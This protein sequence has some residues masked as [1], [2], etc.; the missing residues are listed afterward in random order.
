M[1]GLEIF[2]GLIVEAGGEDNGFTR[3]IR[4][5][6]TFDLDVADTVITKTTTR[7]HIRRSIRKHIRIIRHLV[8]DV[9]ILGALHHALL[10]LDGGLS[11]HTDLNVAHPHV[12]H[13]VDRPPIRPIRID[14]DLALVPALGEEV[15]LVP[16]DVHLLRVL[17]DRA[18]PRNE[19]RQ[20]EAE[21]NTI[22]ALRE[23]LP[24]SDQR[25]DV[26]EEVVLTIPIFR[27]SVV[28]G[29]PLLALAF[30][31]RLLE[32]VAPPRLLVAGDLEV[33][34]VDLRLLRLRA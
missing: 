20:L 19:G 5:L 1:E 10:L 23:D 33:D 7:L 13:E 11:A 28:D 24:A 9:E 29:S 17:A 6:R 25:E 27:L 22:L 8:H 30:P 4:V 26:P 34:G 32:A 2:G 21:R 12:V 31:A 15:L 3:T 16:R 14:K 18:R